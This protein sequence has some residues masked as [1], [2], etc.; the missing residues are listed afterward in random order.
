MNSHLFKLEL[1]HKKARKNRD[2]LRATMAAGCYH[3]VRIFVTTKIVDW[4]DDGM[5]AR[6]PHCG[7]DSVLPGV[8]NFDQ[9]RA[10]QKHWFNQ[11]E[12]NESQA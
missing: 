12:S 11:G 10:A 3:C 2:E 8:V 1:C 7:I 5:T 6:C 9:L 4:L